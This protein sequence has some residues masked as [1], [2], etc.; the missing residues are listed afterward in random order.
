MS[1]KKKS[2]LEIANG[3]YVNKSEIARL[4]GVAHVRGAKIFNQAQKVEIAELK[5]N[6]IDRT[7]VRTATMLKVLGLTREDIINNALTNERK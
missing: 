1:R 6:Y 5:D 7:K 2:L 4:L 3:V